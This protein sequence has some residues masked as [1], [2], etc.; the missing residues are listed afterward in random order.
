MV[1]AGIHGCEVIAT[2]LA[3]E[4]VERLASPP[5]SA[6]AKAVLDRGD[7]VVMPTVNVDGRSASL[8]SL[9]RRRWW[10]PAPR[11]NAHGVDLNRHWPFP[12]GVRDSWLPIS[13]VGV[14]WLPWY[15]GTEPLSEPENRAVAGTAERTRPAVLLNLHSTGSIL[16]S[17]WGC[18]PEAPAPAAVA[19]WRAMIAAFNAA[20]PRWRYRS[21]QSR[22][23]YPILGNSND[24][25]HD[26]FGT[27]SMTVETSPPAAEVK[28]SPRLGRWAF[29]YANPVDRDAWVAND[30]GGCLAALDEGLDRGPIRGG[31]PSRSS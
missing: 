6:A 7:V 16:T 3:L 13:G 26:R 22:A 28:R 18:K 31:T 14:D 8:S 24:W 15:R 4:L 11:R 23:W 10:N 30:V 27:L 12:D 2:E 29:W 9:G 21:K 5:P 19:A 1:I 20:Q 17:P 25:F